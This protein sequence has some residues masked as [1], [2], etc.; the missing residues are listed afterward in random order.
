MGRPTTRRPQPPRSDRPFRS[1]GSMRHSLFLLRRDLPDVHAGLGGRGSGSRSWRGEFRDHFVD[2]TAAVADHKQG[3]DESRRS[4]R[5]GHV[6]VEGRAARA[7]RINGISASLLPR[8]CEVGAGEVVAD[9]I[10]LR[11]MAVA[12]VHPDPGE[13]LRRRRRRRRRVS[14]T[15]KRVFAFECRVR[16]PVIVRASCPSCTAQHR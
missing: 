10:A 7:V 14:G 8:R 4:G 9:V 2:V 5:N 15:S 1:L 12:V 11:E 6:P 13:D 16:A 3:R